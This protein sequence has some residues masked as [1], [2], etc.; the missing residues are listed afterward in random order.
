[1]IEQSASGA[2]GGEIVHLNDGQRQRGSS[3]NETSMTVIK[4]KNSVGQDAVPPSAKLLQ[5]DQAYTAIKQFLFQEED[6]RNYF[7]ERFLA[8]ELDMGLASVRSAVER[9][10]SEGIVEL[11]PKAGIRLPQI[12]HEEIMDFFEVRLV[13]E[14]YIA[15]QVAQRVTREQCKELMELI[16]SQKLAA[17]ERDTLTYHQLDL[18]FHDCIARI[19]GNLEMV[20]TL[21][22][23]GDKMYRLSRR[24]HQRQV[25]HLSVN[26]QQHEKIVLAI[27]EGRADDAS[28]AMRAHLIWGRNHTLDPE[29]RLEQISRGTI[30]A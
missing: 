3:R 16:E 18:A 4:A 29:G 1:M 9:L 6:T 30:T 15:Q 21:Q 11:I 14:P 20:R 17:R 2:Y 24:I 25:E 10:R 12:T 27:C 5:K 28:D 26:A 13:I 7:S 19:H 8:G 22:Q 23:L